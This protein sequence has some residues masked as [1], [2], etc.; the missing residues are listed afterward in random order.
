MMK[1]FGGAV[2]VIWRARSSTLVS[3]PRSSMTGSSTRPLDATSTYDAI[4]DWVK[5]LACSQSVRS[6]EV[7]FVTRSRDVAW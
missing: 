7:L 3:S 2:T 1:V 6:P 5:L 4:R